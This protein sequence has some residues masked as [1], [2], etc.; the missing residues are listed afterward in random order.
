MTIRSKSDCD[1]GRLYARVRVETKLGTDRIKQ[2]V[3]EFENEEDRKYNLEKG[4]GHLA[5]V[6]FVGG[7]LRNVKILDFEPGKF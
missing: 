5:F 3:V 2:L 4:P 7:I 1:E 6:S